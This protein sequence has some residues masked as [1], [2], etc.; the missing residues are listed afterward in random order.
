MSGLLK[1]VLT[2]QE[3]ML[4]DALMLIE[5]LIDE[6]IDEAGLRSVRV[7]ARQLVDRMDNPDEWYFIDPK[8]GK[9][10]PERKW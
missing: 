4:L 10:K 3:H 6:T 7:Q 5:T 9:E 8:T 2:E 1:T